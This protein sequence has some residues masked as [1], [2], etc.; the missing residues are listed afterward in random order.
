MSTFYLFLHC[1]SLALMLA[2]QVRAIVSISAGDAL[3]TEMVLNCD[4]L[5][6]LAVLVRSPN[7]NLRANAFLMYA[8]SRCILL[9]LTRKQSV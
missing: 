9:H 4:I 5:P 8:T 6:R 2:L 7:Q 1:V 3:Q